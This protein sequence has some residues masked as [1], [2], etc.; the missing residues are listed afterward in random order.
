MGSAGDHLASLPESKNE[1]R[2]SFELKIENQ[3]GRI[4][5]MLTSLSSRYRSTSVAQNLM[6]IFQL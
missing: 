4:N 1:E 5:S 6:S 3:F 2:V